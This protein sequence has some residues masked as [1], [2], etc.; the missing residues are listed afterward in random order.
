ML[1]SPDVGLTTSVKTRMSKQKSVRILQQRAARRL[2]AWAHLVGLAQY[3]LALEVQ[4]RNGYL[5]PTRR[6]YI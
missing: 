1:Y 5:S 3:I 2:K 4:S 6:K